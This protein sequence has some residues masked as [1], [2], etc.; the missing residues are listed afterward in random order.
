MPRLEERFSKVYSKF[1]L[2]FYQ[3]IFSRFQD[4]EASLTTVETFAME[5]IHALG[6]PTVHQFAKFMNVSSSNAAYKIASL[7]R[8]GYVE[9]VQSDQDGRE[10]HLSPTQKYLDYYNVSNEY[11]HTVMERVRARLAPEDLAKLE[12]ILQVMGEELMPEIE[13][14]PAGPSAEDAAEA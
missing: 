12:E 3:E 6:S 1:K 7:V 10:Y 14:P 9:K 13:L 5:A 11:V 2:H 4:R 8:K